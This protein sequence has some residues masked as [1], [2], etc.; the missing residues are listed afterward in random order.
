MKSKFSFAGDDAE[1][2]M[3]PLIDCVFLLLIFFLVTTMLKKW[4]KQIPIRL[5]EMKFATSDFS[6]ETIK[7]LAVDEK[8]K[9]YQALGKDESGFD[10]F[11]PVDSLEE[12][13]KKFAKAKSEVQLVVPSHLDF[14]KIIHFLDLLQKEGLNNVGLRLASEKRN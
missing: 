13:C 10:I 5:P 7:K 9:F 1:I 6:V 3:S 2:S 4:E 14:Q 11:S 12:I 8:G